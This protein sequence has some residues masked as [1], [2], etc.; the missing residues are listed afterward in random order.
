MG[1]SSP[2]R[3]ITSL[4]LSEEW[5]GDW[6]LMGASLSVEVGGSSGV[7]V[8]ANVSPTGA[9]RTG[10]DDIRVRQGAL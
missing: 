6:C 4:Q 9:V 2:G 3:I 1:S 5:D 8:Q 10:D 7:A